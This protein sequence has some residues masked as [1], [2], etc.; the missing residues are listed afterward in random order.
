LLAAVL[1]I[2]V[3]LNVGGLR[4]R[5][6]GEP[7]QTRIESLAVLPLE[8]LSGDLEQEYFADGMTEALI[9]DLAKIGALK[10]ISRTSVMQYKGV[11]RPLPEIAEELNVDAVIEGSVLQSGDR[12]RITA[13]LIQ[14]A[15]DQHLWAESYERDLKDILALQGEV[16]RAI[17]E[18]IEVKLTPREEARLSAARS[19]DPEAHTAYLRGRYSWNQG[20]QEGRKRA[21]EYFHQ[22]IEIDPD[23]A[24]GHVALADAYLISDEPSPEEARRRGIAAAR[25]ALEIDS[26]LGEAHATLAFAHIFEWE[27][28]AAEKGF[29]RAIE[30]SPSYARA[31]Y[32]YCMYLSWTG[33]H[34]EAIA[35]A[36]RARN[37]DPASLGMANILGNALYFARQYD[38]AIEHYRKILEVDEDFA[39]AQFDLARA[40][41]Q[42]G[43][44][45]EAIAEFK[46]YDERYPNL[47]NLAYLGHAYAV[48]GERAEAERLL[49][50]LKAVQDP[51][52]QYNVPFDLAVIYV[53]LGQEEEAFQWLEKAYEEQSSNLVFLKTDPRFDPIRSD[54]RYQDLLRRLN[55][56][57]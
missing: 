5:M 14:A 52:H 7:S 40:Y 32:R 15:T 41:L 11:K 49:T 57:E 46:Y 45:E 36:H 39:L 54:L 42:K 29:Q 4:D 44:F 13:Q 19:V 53:A 1:A 33:R 21:I 43:M 28:E 37:V 38:R 56:P 8:N 6:L 51:T 31:H 48:A 2:V 47:W 25:R 23:Y 22:A 16:A 55:F 18:E 20:T 30:L 3:A 50:R 12:V 27:W 24:Q 17:A 26:T 9:T 10:V 34:E 35:E